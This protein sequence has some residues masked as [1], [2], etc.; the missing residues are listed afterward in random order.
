MM[1][2]FHSIGIIKHDEILYEMGMKEKEHEV[3]FLEVIR[4]AKWLPIFEKVFSWGVNTSQNDVNFERK[5][6]V[7]ESSKYCKN[8]RKDR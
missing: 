2:Y 6:S 7:P 5:F 4:E 1:Q 8:Y 3:Y